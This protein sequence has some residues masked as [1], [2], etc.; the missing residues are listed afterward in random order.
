[1]IKFYYVVYFF[2]F[3]FACFFSLSLS[4]ATEQVTFR[5]GRISPYNAVITLILRC[6]FSLMLAVSL[7]IIDFENAFEWAN[8]E[9]ANEI[10]KNRIPN[11][12]RSLNEANSRARL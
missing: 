1:M 5:G 10:N 7:E 8:R 4:A 6:N 9:S 12:N 2:G 11:I 3:S